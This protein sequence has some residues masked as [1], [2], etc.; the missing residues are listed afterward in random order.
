LEKGN[1]GRWGLHLHSH[2][3]LPF[4]LGDLNN[5]RFIPG[6]RF[7]TEEEGDYHLPAEVHRRKWWLEY[8]PC[9]MFLPKGLPAFLVPNHELSV[10][11]DP[12]SDP[13]I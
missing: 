11:S 13:L 3:E 1:T 4:K 8:S 9:H 6:S 7:L 2:D 10:I 5:F 12:T